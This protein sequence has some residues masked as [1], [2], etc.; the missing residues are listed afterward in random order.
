MEQIRIIEVDLSAD[1]HFIG[2]KAAFWVSGGKMGSFIADGKEMPP[3]GAISEARIVRT[4][5]WEPP[6]QESRGQSHLLRVRGA[7]PFTSTWSPVPV[8][9]TVSVS[10]PRAPS[11]L[12]YDVPT[13]PPGLLGELPVLDVSISFTRMPSLILTH[14]AESGPSHCLHRVT[15][16]P[17]PSYWNLSHCRQIVCPS[18]SL[19]VGVPST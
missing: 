18:I 12:T 3:S 5:V 15:P 4:M 7:D 17:N 10:L 13:Q 2:I 8:C 6:S 1:R 11:S 16:H 9:L 14:Q 19:W